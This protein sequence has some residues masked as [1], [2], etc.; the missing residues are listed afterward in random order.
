[1]RDPR[2]APASGT[3]HITAH[4]RIV[5]GTPAGEAFAQ[6]GDG[7]AVHGG[8]DEV[9]EHLTLHGTNWNSD[10]SIIWKF[11]NYARF[12]PPY[13]ANFE[14]AAEVLRQIS[15]PAL[16][17]WGR[18][19]FARDPEVTGEAAAIRDHRVVRVE[20]AGHWLHHDQL[21]VFLTETKKFLAA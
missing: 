3:F 11:D 16:L 17:F 8:F 1:M 19:S 9:A 10:G 2:A 13:G 12:F 21:E 20:Q 5:F 15:C 14:E 7:P 4:D 18:A 6:P